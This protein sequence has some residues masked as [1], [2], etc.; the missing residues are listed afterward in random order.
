MGE[1][2]A[3]APLRPARTAQCAKNQT[4]TGRGQWVTR[5]LPMLLLV[6]G[7]LLKASLVVGWRIARIETALK[8]ETVYDPLSFWLA[9]EGVRLGF[10]QRRIAPSMLE[11]L[12]FEV[13]LILGFA[14]QCFL[15]GMISK[16]I[17]V[18]RPRTL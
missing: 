7:V 13:L 12:T 14:L 8:I 16:A 5:R 17:F 6:S 10:D 11:S 9:P 4:L 1:P 15:V 18:S 3:R 2:D